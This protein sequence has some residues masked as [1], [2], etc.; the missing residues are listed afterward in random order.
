VQPQGKSKKLALR[1]AQ[2]NIGSAIFCQPHSTWRKLQQH[3][4]AGN[5][6]TDIHA[7]RQPCQVPAPFEL[8][9]KVLEAR[10][11]VQHLHHGRCRRL[12]QLHCLVRQTGR[13]EGRKKGKATPRPEVPFPPGI[14]RRYLTVVRGASILFPTSARGMSGCI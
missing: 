12:V 3:L 7:H 4:L 5:F 13:R 1:Q 9:K 10:G 11:E 2:A 6:Q 8:R 14:D